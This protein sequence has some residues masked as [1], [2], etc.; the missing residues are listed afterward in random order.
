M[1]TTSKTAAAQVYRKK[2]SEILNCAAD[3]TGLMASGE[4]F[5]G[6]PTI[7][8]TGVTTDNVAISSGVLTI[9]STSV[10]AGQAITW[11]VS[12]GTAGT[13]YVMTVTGSTNA[14]PSQTLMLDCILEVEAN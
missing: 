13:I 14:S 8:V 4:A 2:V 9:M 7:T 5:T 10:A 11:R 1:S 3:F 6:T 12:G